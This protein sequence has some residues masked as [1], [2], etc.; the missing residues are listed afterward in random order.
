MDNNETQAKFI[1][2]LS[3]IFCNK[4]CCAD[5]INFLLDK[6][7]N[8]EQDDLDKNIISNVELVKKSADKDYDKTKINGEA[9]DAPNPE[10]FL[11]N[12]K[13]SGLPDE[14]KSAYLKK[15]FE[16]TNGVNFDYKKSFEDNLK[17]MLVRYK[18]YPEGVLLHILRLRLENFEENINNEKSDQ[19]NDF[20][21][22]KNLANAIKNILDSNNFWS[23]EKKLAL[24]WEYYEYFNGINENE[25]LDKEQNTVE[26]FKDVLKKMQVAVIIRKTLN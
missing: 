4:Q 10:E 13:F 15:Y 18:N 7:K 25:K 16:I 24:L 8:T 6:P 3:N 17:A 1:S 19:N 20:A 14:I 2:S 5:Y 12:G 11:K 21:S 22:K 9:L 26:Q 23:D